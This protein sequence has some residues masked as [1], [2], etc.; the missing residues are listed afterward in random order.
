MDFDHH[1]RT[2]SQQIRQQI[3]VV[4]WRRRLRIVLDLFEGPL[5]IH[6]DLIHF[7]TLIRQMAANGLC[8]SKRVSA[9][10]AQQ[11]MTDRMGVFV[12]DSHH[13]RDL[14]QNSSYIFMRLN[15]VTR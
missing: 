6:V 10:F 9:R 3:Y 8:N 1:F 14:H 4:G 11:T 13:E 5:L 2:I 7:T 15:T 12:F